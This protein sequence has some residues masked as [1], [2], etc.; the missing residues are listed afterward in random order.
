MIAVVS[1]FPTKIAA[2]QFEWAW[3]HPGVSKVVREATKG[4]HA[5]RGAKAKLHVLFVLLGVE[6]FV[7]WPLALRLAS[8]DI[9][10]LT[11]G[12]PPL[13]AFVRAN[14]SVG[15][16]SEMPMYAE[17][18]KKKRSRKLGAIAS[19][20][21][22]DVPQ[23]ATGALAAAAVI[24]GSF[25]DLSSSS[26]EDDDDFDDHGSDCLGHLDSGGEE[27]DEDGAGSWLV[28]SQA[29]VTGTR[30]AHSAAAVAAVST[31]CC[32]CRDQL[33]CCSGAAYFDCTSCGS[34]SHV[35][36]LSDHMLLHASTQGGAVASDPSDV[37]L[38][39][40]FP[41]QPAPCP[42][43]LGRVLCIR[44]LVWQ[45][46]V[47]RVRSRSPSLFQL[48]LNAGAEGVVRKKQR[49]RGRTKQQPSAGRQGVAA[50]VAP[51]AASGMSFARAPLPSII[52]L[53][54]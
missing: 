6:P 22:D 15:P 5:K 35:R 24:A 19:T 51:P 33:E 2:Q 31:V 50:P 11:A 37:L 34:L 1:G 41:V 10:V 49:R 44:S 47:A 12:L 7:R 39:N 8:E 46:V 4:L 28:G 45:D 40:L 25:I 36:C 48:K 20:A 13:P 38:D 16:I 42:G 43:V 52:D 14:S 27:E 3:Q 17:T 18:M 54:D 9:T 32:L 30:A 23:P 53:S 26:D 29:R 21:G